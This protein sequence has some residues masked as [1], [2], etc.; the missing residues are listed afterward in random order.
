MQTLLERRAWLPPFELAGILRI[1][2]RAI[3]KLLRK[4]ELERIGCTDSRCFVSPHGV[5]KILESR[6]Y[7]FPRKNYSFQSMRGRVGKTSLAFGFAT[8]ASHY[9]ARVL[10]IDFDPQGGLT[11]ALG[12]ARRRD[13]PIWLDLMRCPSIPVSDAV[14]RTE[15]IDVI[16]SGLANW[17][18]DTELN[19]RSFN[20]KDIIEERIAPVR[21]HY[22]IVVMDCPPVTSKIN[23]AVVC[24]SDRVIIP[25]NPG[26]SAIDDMQLQVGELAD[27]RQNFKADFSHSIIWNQYDAQEKLG[28]AYMRDLAR[29]SELSESVLSTVI[30]IDSSIRNAV[31][32]YLFSVYPAGGS[33]IFKE[34]IGLIT[35]EIFDKDGW[36]DAVIKSSKPS[37]DISPINEGAQRSLDRNQKF[38]FLRRRKPRDPYGKEIVSVFRYLA[39]RCLGRE[40]PKLT[41]EEIRDGANLASGL[42]AKTC[43]IRLVKKNLIYR[44]AVVRGR[45]GGA[46]YGLT[47]D[48]YAFLRQLKNDA[49]SL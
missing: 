17:E 9:G 41:R 27:L 24:A 2:P 30:R 21:D 5:R 4:L 11:R 19:S 46:I 39:C 49:L 36:R 35:R 47:P 10:A 42:T 31:D 43:L 7:V 33:S 22:D 8:H 20:L 12:V 32:D 1:N 48:G 6:G 28:H 29:I 23:A 15:Y 13:Q 45:N 44:S 37:P 3:H 16:P 34:D 40:T 18:L 25:I 38:G 14:L 26:S